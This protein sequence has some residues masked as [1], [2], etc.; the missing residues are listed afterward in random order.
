MYFIPMICFVMFPWVSIYPMFW[1][2]WNNNENIW[3]TF[4]YILN[5]NDQFCYVTT[6]FI[7]FINMKSSD[8]SEPITKY[9]RH[10]DLYYE[11][12]WLVLLYFH[13]FQCIIMLWFKWSNTIHMRLVKWAITILCKLH[14]VIASFLLNTIR[15][16]SFIPN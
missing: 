5:S 4:M 1:F 13:V 16:K 7:Y 12:Q 14:P 8:I 9:M 6:C 15:T 2:K 10:I 3:G 11:F